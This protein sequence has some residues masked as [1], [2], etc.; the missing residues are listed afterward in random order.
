M[1]DRRQL[2]ARHIRRRVL[3][4]QLAGEI[5]VD[6]VPEAPLVL[7]YQRGRLLAQ[8]GRE[9]LRNLLD[10]HSAHVHPA[11]RR[12]AKRDLLRG[13]QPHLEQ[14]PLPAAGLVAGDPRDRV[15]HLAQRGRV[16]AAASIAGL[17]KINARWHSVVQLGLVAQGKPA[18]LKNARG[19][20]DQES[21]GVVYRPNSRDQWSAQWQSES[22]ALKTG[23]ASSDAPHR[24][25]TFGYRRKISSTQWLEGFF[26]EDRDLVSGSVPEIANVGPDFTAGLRLLIRL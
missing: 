8:P 2:R 6:H 25:V 7:G 17:L 4:R 16:D 14:D 24:L 22:S 26:S 21:L 19:L 3:R 13:H 9:P 10:R 1:D 12:L 11:G 23:E 20:V 5:G 15:R 18:R